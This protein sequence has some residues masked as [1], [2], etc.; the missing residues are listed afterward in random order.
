MSINE[1][2]HGLYV[3]SDDT[4]TPNTTI[5]EQI[6]EALK[7]GA[8]IVQLRDKK[9]P[10]EQVKQKAI[11]IQNLC[12]KYGAIFILNDH[13]VMAIE[14]D[15]DGLHIGKSDHDKFEYLRSHY[16]GIIGVSCYGDVNLAKE[17]EK[18]GAN[19]VAFGSFYTSPTKPNSNIIP[20]DILKE[21]KQKLTIPVCAI[22][23]IDTKNISTIMQYKPSM[24]SLISDI[25][26]SDDIQTQSQFYAQQ[27]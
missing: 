2:L 13:T 4:L 27:F 6:E 21:A 10:Y 19:Y 11:H 16:K 23:G 22:G 24:V 26:N 14:M 1:K 20:L 7:G 17:F 8:K 25:W 18:K 9:N 12:H 5:I 15:A 3:I